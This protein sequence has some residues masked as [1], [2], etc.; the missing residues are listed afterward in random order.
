M[1]TQSPSL[2]RP[3]RV[4]LALAVALALLA[5]SCGS[6]DSTE[7]ADPSTDAADPTDAPAAPTDAPAAPTDAPAAPTDAPEAP[8]E[9]PA[10]ADQGLVVTAVDID[11]GV[12]TITNTG[13]TDIDLSGHQLCNRPTYVP[14][15]DEVL[16]AG[17]SMDFGLGLMSADGGEV[18]LY[19]SSDFG[20][21][22]A[23][24]SYVTWGSGGGRLSVAAEGGDWSGDPIPDP[25]SVLT[26]TGTPGDASGWSG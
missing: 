6:D 15:P 10:A 20:N 26:L 19:T 1:T 16:A 22:D 2:K 14:L 13:T 4:L 11:A 7:T 9:V 12:V 3:G 24:I 18:G 21:S 25:G 8:T 23:L 5:A 17:E